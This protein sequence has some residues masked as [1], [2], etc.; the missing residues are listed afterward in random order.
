MWFIF[1]LRFI[2]LILLNL[3]D[4]VICLVVLMFFF[5]CI[6][7]LLVK[8][9]FFLLLSCWVEI[10]GVCLGYVVMRIY[11]IILVRFKV[12]IIWNIVLFWIFLWRNF[13]WELMENFVYLLLMLMDVWLVVEVICCVIGIC[14]LLL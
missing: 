12:Y 6:V 14:Y 4:L 3:W 9:F 13:V 11:I 7:Y 1:Y 8:I 10:I 5:I 2:G